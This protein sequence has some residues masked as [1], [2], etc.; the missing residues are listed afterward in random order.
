MY[1]A[2]RRHQHRQLSASATAWR[3]E[4]ARLMGGSAKRRSG[5]GA[6]EEGA[7][8]NMLRRNVVWLEE[9]AEPA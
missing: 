5:G 6:G 1:P 7:K 2:N 3:G 8:R 9:T 4:K